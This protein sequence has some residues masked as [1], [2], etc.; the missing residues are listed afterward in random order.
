MAKS[1]KRHLLAM[2]PYLIYEL[3]EGQ[4]NRAKSS[5]SPGA[6]RGIFEE[7]VRDGVVARISCTNLASSSTQ[8]CHASKVF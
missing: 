8:Q 3:W 4:K 5:R 7:L 2:L 1:S 6:S